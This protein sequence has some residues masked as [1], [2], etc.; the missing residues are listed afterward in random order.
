MCP[1]GWIAD[2]AGARGFCVSMDQSGV[3]GRPSIGGWSITIAIQVTVKLSLK[4]SPTTK[5]GY[6]FFNF[7]MRS[8]LMGV[9]VEGRRS[10]E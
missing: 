9:Y 7:F 5:G 10:H 4:V 1:Q 2:R 6:L 8:T 3:T